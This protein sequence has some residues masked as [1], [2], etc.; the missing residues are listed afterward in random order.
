MIISKRIKTISIICLLFFIILANFFYLQIIQYDLFS[1]RA[2]SKVVR[3]IPVDA[4]RGLIKDRRGKDIV[5]NS[6]VY[7][8]Q[9]LPI[10]VKDNFNYNDLANYIKFDSSQI[11]IL[12]NK[13]STQGFVRW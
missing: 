11:N 1:D 3:K 9:V 13:I 2:I 10:D 4:Q 7:D 12:K 6:N 8:L 5:R